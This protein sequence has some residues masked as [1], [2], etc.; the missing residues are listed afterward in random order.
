MR[1]RRQFV[2]TVTGAVLASRALVNAAPQAGAAATRREVRVGG[3]R[4]KVVAA[5]AHASIAE[6]ADVVK[7]TPL[8]RFARGGGRPLGPDRIQEL[9]KRGIDLQAL[10]DTAF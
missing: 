7:G 5:H 3:K 6:V 10:S 2:Q 4:V 1:N 8:E 9:D